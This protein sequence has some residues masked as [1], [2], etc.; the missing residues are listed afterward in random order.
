MKL[1]TSEKSV[2]LIEAENVIIIEVGM[3]MRKPEIKKEFEEMFGVKVMK[4]R[5]HIKRNKKI[6]YIKLDP[7]DQAVDIAA[8]FGMI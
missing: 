5:T 3:K 8:K 6:A 4:V 1:K 7:K 2:R